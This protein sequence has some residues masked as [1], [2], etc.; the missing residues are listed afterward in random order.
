M[1]SMLPEQSVT[2]NTLFAHFAL[3]LAIESA[4]V[5]WKSNIAWPSPPLTKLFKRSYG[6]AVPTLGGHRVQPTPLCGSSK[7]KLP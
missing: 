6:G 3:P 4:W 2:A 1:T 7:F 5:A